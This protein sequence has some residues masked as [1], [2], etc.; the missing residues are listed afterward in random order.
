MKNN[1]TSQ[2]LLVEDDGAMCVFLDNHYTKNGSNLPVIIQK[3]DL[4][5]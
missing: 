3:S 2:N 4:V 5:K 1:L